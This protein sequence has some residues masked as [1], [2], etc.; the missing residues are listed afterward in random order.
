ML[1]GEGAGT[2]FGRLD[3]K[4]GTLCLSPTNNTTYKQILLEMANQ[5]HFLQQLKTLGPFIIFGLYALA[6]VNVVKI[7][8][9][10]FENYGVRS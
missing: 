10:D 5:T 9:K 3:R 6:K 4:P 7:F 8:Y 1:T 2:Q